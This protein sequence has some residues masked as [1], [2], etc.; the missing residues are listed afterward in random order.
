MEN[1]YSKLTLEQKALL[2]IDWIAMMECRLNDKP[3]DMI[4]QFA[5]VA[6]DICPNK[7]DD[8]RQELEKFYQNLV[9]K[10][11]LDIEELDLDEAAR[12]ERLDYEVG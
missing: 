7:H 4:Y 6:A 3:L 12:Q 10:G 9:D 5:H 1:K 8:W 11:E 2:C